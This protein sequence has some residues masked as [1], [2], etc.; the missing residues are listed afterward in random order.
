M[1]IP[2][3]MS[4]A[5]FIATAPQLNFMGTGAARFHARIG[6][7]HFRRNDDGSFAKLDSTLHDLVVYGKTAERAY[8]RFKVGDSFVAS[9]YID[10]FEVDHNGRTEARE[11]FVARRIGHDTARTKYAVDRT[12]TRQPDPPTAD[13]HM[14]KNRAPA[15]GI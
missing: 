8:S 10:E 14:V 2:T 1:T 7:E 3:Q 4:L 12:P 13:L 6:V 15:V 5:G 11:Q 9:G